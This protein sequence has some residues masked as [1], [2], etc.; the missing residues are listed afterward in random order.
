MTPREFQDILESALTAWIDAGDAAATKESYPAFTTRCAAALA[1]AA[2]GLSSGC[3][4][5]VCTSGGVLA[6]VCAALL[7]A[8]NTFLPV[9]RVAVNAGLTKVVIGR[10]GATLVSLNEHGHLEGDGRSLVT[11]R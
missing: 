10:Q 1:D 6:A 8:P 9:N 3:A 5:L 11:Y 7:Q 2:A 4:A